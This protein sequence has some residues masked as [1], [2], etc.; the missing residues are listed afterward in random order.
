MKALTKNRTN[1]LS[2][3]NY[4]KRLGGF[5]PFSPWGSFFEDITLPKLYD[6]GHIKEENEKEYSFEFDMP[7]LDKEDIDIS[8]QDG[9][10]YINGHKKLENRERN[11]SE[12]ISLSDVVC[13]KDIK[14]EYKSGVL[15][16]K[17]P[18][19]QAE[20]PKVKKIVVE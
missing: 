18:K 17:I 7:G 1:S 2:R 11:Y 16:L 15:S 9:Y 5:S 8:V 6:F 4:G 12:T 13:E 14:A 10:L 19:K 3:D 20:I